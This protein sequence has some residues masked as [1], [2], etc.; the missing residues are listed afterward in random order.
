VVKI[1]DFGIAHL[2]T[3]ELTVDGVVLGTPFYMSP[4]QLQGRPVDGRTDLYSLGT[5]L[6]ELLTGRRPYPQKSLPDL[7][8]AILQQPV[9]DPLAERSDVPRELASVVVRCL[10]K[11]PDERHDS[12]AELMHALLAAVPTSERL[13][14]LDT[15]FQQER[16]SKPREGGGV[17]LLEDAGRIH[18]RIGSELLIGRDASCHIQLADPRVSRKHAVVSMSQGGASLTDLASAN[19][20]TRN[21][22]AVADTIALRHRDVVGIGGAFELEVRLRKQGGAVET[23]TLSSG[24]EKHLLARSE[25]VIG[26]DPGQADIVVS[27]QGVSPESARIEFLFDRPILSADRG[28]EP[29]LVSGKPTLSV[30]LEEGTIFA[31]GC[32]P[33]RWEADTI[34]S[35]S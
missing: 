10:A 2:A 16:Q 13:R 11:D 33:M 21:G 15:T 35:A 20:C 30:R 9:P 5:V 31:I 32:T 28:E 17:L 8:K 34:A 6:F 22:Q 25:V 14:D 7:A 19:G 29:I 24:S 18:I 4:E 27:D 12:G 26:S 1:T 3:S 23:I